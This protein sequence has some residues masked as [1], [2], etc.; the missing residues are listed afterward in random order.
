MSRHKPSI[1]LESVNKTTYISD[2]ILAAE[3]AWAVCYDGNPVNLKSHNILVNYPAPKYKKMVFVNP[4]HAINL[5]KKL[6]IQFNTN[7]FTVLLMTVGTQV[8]P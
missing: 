1:I 5:C 8:Y 2:Q 3:G 7:K 4:G 6:N